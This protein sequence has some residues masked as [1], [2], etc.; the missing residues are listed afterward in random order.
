MVNNNN[1]FRFEDNTMLLSAY[2]EKLKRTGRRLIQSEIRIE[3][4]NSENEQCLI[5]TKVG[6]CSDLEQNI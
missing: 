2:V 4:E 6:K 5:V 1:N 3:D